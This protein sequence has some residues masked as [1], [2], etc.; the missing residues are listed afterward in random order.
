MSFP[1]KILNNLASKLKSAE[2]LGET[3]MKDFPILEVEEYEAKL[4]ENSSQTPREFFAQYHQ[5]STPVVANRSEQ[6]L[7]V[8]V[9]HQAVQTES[10]DSMLQNEVDRLKRMVTDLVYENNRYHYKLSNCTCCLSDDAYHDVSIASFDESIRAST[11][12][13]FNLPSSDSPPLP[14][15]VPVPGTTTKTTQDK[16]SSK[17][18]AYIS[19]LVRCLTKLEKKYQ[20]PPHKRKERIFRRKTKNKSIVPKEFSSIYL[21]LA[22][23]ESEVKSPDLSPPKVDWPNVRFRPP[24]PNPV[25]CTVYSCSEDPDFYKEKT[26]CFHMRYNLFHKTNPFGTLLG[27]RTTEGV[28]DVPRVPVGGYVYCTE[29]RQWILD[30]SPPRGARKEVGRILSTKRRKG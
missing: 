19:R 12:L 28:I 6:T 14:S 10:A 27:Y 16:R 29:V 2:T 20:T 13:D 17:D 9:L 3:E 21:S 24:L 18:K 7:P 4:R 5:T 22:A 30:A 15:S 1:Y 11:P 8:S 26:D 25:E 23:P